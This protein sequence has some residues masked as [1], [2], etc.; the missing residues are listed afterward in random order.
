MSNEN[1]KIL[2]LFKYINDSFLD[3][4]AISLNDLEMFTNLFMNETTAINKW[5]TTYIDEI[6]EYAPKNIDSICGVSK[7]LGCSSAYKAL[8]VNEKNLLVPYG[9]SKTFTE[10]SIRNQLVKPSYYI[11][12]LIFTLRLHDFH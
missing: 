9:G 4:N 2:F 3:K 8:E 12:S 6:I 5:V 10:I 7:A 1:K 11:N